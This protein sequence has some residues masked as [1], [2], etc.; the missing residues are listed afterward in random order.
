MNCSPAVTFKPHKGS[1]PA[2]LCFMPNVDHRVCTVGFSKQMKRELYLWDQRKLAKPL[3]KKYGGGEH[4]T[5]PSQHTS[6]R[7]YSTRTPRTPRMH[8]SR[9]H[10]HT[11]KGR[12]EGK[13]A[14]V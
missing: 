8:T 1:R 14:C 3:N 12:Q 9:M 11:H 10:T 2:K 5:S 7:T 13:K 4:A 6:T